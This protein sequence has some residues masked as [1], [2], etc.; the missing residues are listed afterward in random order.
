MRK[1]CH[2]RSLCGD[3]FDDDRFEQN[4]LAVLTETQKRKPSVDPFKTP[5]GDS[6]GLFSPS[7]RLLVVFGRLEGRAAR[8]TNRGSWNDVICNCS[9]L[10]PQKVFNL[11]AP[12]L[13]GQYFK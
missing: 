12:T 9:S 8:N 6:P 11:E 10:Q 4:D 2:S 1:P 7:F 13:A 3:R 5:A